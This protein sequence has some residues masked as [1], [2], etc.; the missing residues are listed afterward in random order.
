MIRKYC[1]LSPQLPVPCF[2]LS[3]SFAASVAKG[4]TLYSSHARLWQFDLVQF[5]EP[6]LKQWVLYSFAKTQRHTSYALLNQGRDRVIKFERQ[7]RQN[8]ITPNYC[9]NGF[10]NSFRFTSLLSVKFFQHV[11]NP[12]CPE[13]TFKQSIRIVIYT[14][15][16]QPKVFFV[17]RVLIKWRRFQPGGP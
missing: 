2:S 13:M 11:S 17:Q 5:N 14:F 8:F 6:R 7:R 12:Y 9:T 15:I 1:S 4:K 3:L 16:C 10:P